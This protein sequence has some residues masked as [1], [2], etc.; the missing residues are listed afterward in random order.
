MYKAIGSIVGL[1]LKPDMI[2]NRERVLN[3]NILIYNAHII[4]NLPKDKGIIFAVNHIGP[5]NQVGKLGQDFGITPDVI[6]AP[7][8]VNMLTGKEPKLVGAFNN[9]L[10]VNLPKGIQD[11]LSKFGIGLL[12]SGL[13]ALAFDKRPEASKSRFINEAKDLLQGGTS[14]VIFSEG[15]WRPASHDYSTETN[16]Q[17]G[18]A[19]LSYLT[20]CPIVPLFL[21]VPEEWAG[22]PGAQIKAVVNSPIIVTNKDQFASVNNQ[23]GFDWAQSQILSR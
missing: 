6:V 23:I 20:G 13:N 10:F 8:L 1:S 21:D 5:V 22:L 11:K 9:D 15:V 12:T 14:L 17:N 4:E 19:L 2:H 18:S 3:Q 16:V 7:T